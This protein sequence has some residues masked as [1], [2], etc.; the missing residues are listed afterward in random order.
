MTLRHPYRFLPPILTLF[1]F[2]FLNITNDLPHLAFWLKLSFLVIT[3]SLDNSF[4]ILT[5]PKLYLFSCIKIQI[6]KILILKALISEWFTLLYFSIAFDGLEK[7]FVYSGEEDEDV[8]REEAA[9]LMKDYLPWT[10]RVVPWISRCSSMNSRGVQT[11][12]RVF[13]R[14]PPRL[15]REPPR[16]FREPPG[17]FREPPKLFCEPPRLFR[18]PPGLFRDTFQGVDIIEIPKKERKSFFIGLFSFSCMR[19]R[20]FKSAGIPLSYWTLVYDDLKMAN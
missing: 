19:A 9:P 16:L 5:Y 13:F 4:C 11:T 18:G 3:Y 17:L 2:P 6:F 20:Q 12:S 8:W 14:E 10:P 7:V 15:F 1:H